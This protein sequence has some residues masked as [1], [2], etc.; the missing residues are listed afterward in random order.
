MT[1][2]SNIFFL[3]QLGSITVSKKISI[4]FVIK[5]INAVVVKPGFIG[6]STSY[7]L[8]GTLL[9]IIEIIKAIV[10]IAPS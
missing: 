7:N 10:N 9:L 6:D 2:K 4:L 5:S 1:P 8:V 3:Q